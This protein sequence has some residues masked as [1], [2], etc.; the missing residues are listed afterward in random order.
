MNM[1]RSHALDCLISFLFGALAMFLFLTFVLGGQGQSAWEK[2][3]IDAGAAT[4]RLNTNT[5]KREF[6]WLT[7]SVKG[8]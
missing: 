4:Y 5:W 8:R 3:A 6:V 7:N 1:D 2:T